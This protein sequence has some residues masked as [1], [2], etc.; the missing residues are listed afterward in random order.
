M[1]NGFFANGF[2]IKLIF[3]C[4]FHLCISIVTASRILQMNYSVII[5]S[6]PQLKLVGMVFS[7][8]ELLSSQSSNSCIYLRNLHNA[9]SD[10]ERASFFYITAVPFFFKL[11]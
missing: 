6:F 3:V 2:I 9:D 1:Q 7:Q 5:L 11:L 10:Y 8:R 4:V